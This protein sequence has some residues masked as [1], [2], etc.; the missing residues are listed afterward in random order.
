MMEGIPLSFE[1]Q[2]DEVN[3]LSHE[4]I[5]KFWRYGNGKKE[6]YDATNPISTYFTDRLYVHFGGITPQ[7]SKRIGW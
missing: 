4:Q 3:N 1:E 5:A 7:I 6:W 2:K